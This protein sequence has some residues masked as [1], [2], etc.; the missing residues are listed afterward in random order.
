MPQTDF[1]QYT[2]VG[3][4]GLVADTQGH[5]IVSHS[6]A[7]T[8]AFGLAVCLNDDAGLEVALPDGTKKIAG[9]TV[10][11]AKGHAIDGV[12]AY[13]EFDAVGVLRQGRIWVVAQG[14]VKAGDGVYVI[15]DVA[16]KEGLVGASATAGGATA[17]VLLAGASFATGGA[18]GELVQVTINI[19]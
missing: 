15:H 2:P 5:N 9:F 7:V 14:V 4:A 12:T 19:P 10:A 16:G 17:N 11:V 6:T 8:L 18:D 13:N 1:G 3:Y